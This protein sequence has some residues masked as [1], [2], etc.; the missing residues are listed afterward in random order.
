MA[1]LDAV[2]R[3]GINLQ[4]IT[5]IGFNFEF[6]LQYAVIYLKAEITK[7]PWSSQS[8][9]SARNSVTK[10]SSFLFLVAKVVESRQAISY[11]SV[12]HRLIQLWKYRSV[13][14]L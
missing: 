7:R 12:F 9:G 8:S 6:V 2:P 4:L 1:K 5:S 14:T 11:N 13:K 10:S 3:W